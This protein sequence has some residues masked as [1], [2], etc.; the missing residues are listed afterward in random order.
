MLA[1]S[2]KYHCWFKQNFWRCFLFLFL[3][4]AESFN[5]LWLSFWEGFVCHWLHT[6]CLVEVFNMVGLFFFITISVIVILSSVLD[7]IKLFFLFLFSGSV[8]ESHI[9]TW[10]TRKFCSTDSSTSY[11]TSGKCMYS[12][13][14]FCA[15]KLK[16]KY[17]F[18]LW[19]HLDTH[20]LL[21]LSYNSNC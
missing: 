3:S 21:P 5:S 16:H 12:D 18:S 1:Y 7:M 6:R 8:Q 15:W 2:S 9:A 17:Y 20:V 11:K 19:L 10:P 14:W 13:L 4:A